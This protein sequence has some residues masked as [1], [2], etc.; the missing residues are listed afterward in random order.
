MSFYFF[1]Q[2]DIPQCFLLVRQAYYP[3]ESYLNEG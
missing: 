1:L 3:G 2:Q